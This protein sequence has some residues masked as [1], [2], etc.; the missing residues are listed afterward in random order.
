MIVYLH[1]VKGHSK[2]ELL[3]EEALTS[4]VDRGWAVELVE[5]YTPSTTSCS[6]VSI[7]PNSCLHQKI[8]NRDKNRFTKLAILSNH[9]RFWRTV[10]DTNL[11]AIYAEHDVICTQDRRTL[12]DFDDVLLLN[13]DKYNMDNHLLEWVYCI[14][15]EFRMREY[16]RGVHDLPEDWPWLYNLHETVYKGSKLV[17]GAGCYAITPQGAKKILDAIDEYG[18]EQGDL[19]LNTLNVDIKFLSPSIV[20][21][22]SGP[23]LTKSQWNSYQ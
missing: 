17:P 6:D 16:P 19:N 13:L 10:V 23:P 9:L 3:K 1:Y 15:T 21:F 20:K 11:P 4:F 22:R 7:I 5:G 2:S 8:T 12:P 14:P 18:A